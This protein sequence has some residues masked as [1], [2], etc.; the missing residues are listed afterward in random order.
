MSVKRIYAND[1]SVIEGIR[2]GDAD[3]ALRFVYQEHY[4]IIR[5]FIIKNSGSANDAQDIF[6]E[7]VIVFYEKALKPDFKLSCALST[8][9]YSV[10]RNLWLKR[11]NKKGKT[12]VVDTNNDFEVIDELDTIDHEALNDREQ[13]LIEALEELGDPCKTGLRLRYFGK[14]SIPQIVEKMDNYSTENGAK[15]QL[16]KCRKRLKKILEQKFGFD[17]HGK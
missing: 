8:Y 9:L 5:D 17:G 15:N 11:L 13:Q 12:L 3:G 14:L 4:H 1:K 2:S 6:Q 16:S 10:A 7:A